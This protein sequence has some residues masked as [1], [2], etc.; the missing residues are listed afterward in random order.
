LKPANGVG[1]N[2]DL[3]L[4]GFQAFGLGDRIQDRH[5]QV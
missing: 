4:K 3:A 1:E 5:G 2:R